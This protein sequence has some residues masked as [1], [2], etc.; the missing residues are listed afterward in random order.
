M[1]RNEHAVGKL[2]VTGIPSGSVINYA[3]WFPA[4]S[5]CRIAVPVTKLGHS[6]QR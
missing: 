5:T 4:E 6:K 2:V 1:D 3:P